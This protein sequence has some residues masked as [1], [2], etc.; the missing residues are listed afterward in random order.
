MVLSQEDRLCECLLILTALLHVFVC[1]FTKVEETFNL[2]AIHDIL[3]KGLSDDAISRVCVLYALETSLV[4][5]TTALL[6][7]V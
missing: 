4:I 7:P 1:P 3:T 6:L 5:L 2:H